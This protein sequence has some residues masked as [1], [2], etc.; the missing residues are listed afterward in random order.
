MTED[1]SSSHG[2]QRDS[3]SRVV[4][5]ADRTAEAD[6][7]ASALRAVGFSVVT[8]DAIALPERVARLEPF[9]V[10]LDLEQSSAEEALEQLLGMETTG[11]DPA[12]LLVCSPAEAERL[13]LPAGGRTKLL[14]RPLHPGDVVAFLSEAASQ[15]AAPTSSLEASPSLADNETAMLSD[16]PAIAGLPEVESIL[17][18]LEHSALHGQQSVALSP[19]IEALLR[20]SAARVQQAGDR[21]PATSAADVQVPQE[22]MAVLDDLLGTDDATPA[23]PPLASGVHPS[24]RGGG[25]TAEGESVVTVDRASEIPSTGVGTAVAEKTVVPSG[26][27]V[28]F[29]PKSPDA[30]SSPFPL[31]R[32]RGPR[33]PAPIASQATATGVESASFHISGPLS[34]TFGVAEP[35]PGA[36]PS[37]RPS[38]RRDTPQPPE[39]F[40]PATSLLSRPIHASELAP[41]SEP[42]ATRAQM[43]PLGT[44][45]ARDSVAPLTTLGQPSFTAFDVAPEPQPVPS[46]PQGDPVWMVAQA[47]CDRFTGALVLSTPEGRRARRVLMRDGDM[48]NAASDDPEDALVNFLVERGDLRPDDARL[49]STKLPPTG[50]HAVAALIANGF[51]SQ[52]D[53]WPVLRAHAEWIIAR[54]LRQR[55][56]RG[57]VEREPSERLR[58]EPNVFGGAAGVEVLIESVRRAISSAEA[59]A[60]LGGARAVLEVGERAALLA[61]SALSPEDTEQVRRSIGQNL[62]D[63][64]RGSGGELAAVLYALVALRIL[65]ARA[66]SGRPQ[67]EGPADYD[68]LDADAV[69]LRVRARLALVSDADYFALLGLPP[70]ATS[71]DIRRA[72]LELRRAF[73]PSRLLTAA[74]AELHDDVAMIV[75]VLE[76]AYEVLRDPHRRGRYRRAIEATRE[77]V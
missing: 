67:P 51:L 43:G 48:V 61:E 42:P 68:P 53:L 63:A 52:D 74:T 70:S 8:S 72:Y 57:N 54:A 31:A 56:S 33:A 34:S 1:K 62:N 27:Q 40:A 26:T 10:L 9:A 7:V 46:V 65:D 5:I 64:L 41:E 58:A 38:R 13:G 28:G 18:E 66:P 59:I 32:P 37:D 77:Q 75:E 19:E 47:V 35:A 2:G 39:S 17:P 55:P 6:E 60:A 29:A 22:M 12:L 69:R 71:Y 25:P 30:V 50:R 36:L 73:D 16:F 20:A 21:G 45:T 23:A 14:S 49:R 24:A 76:E 3:R 11:D 44:M 4:L 15:T